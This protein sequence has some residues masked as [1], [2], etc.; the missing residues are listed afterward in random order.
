MNFK[1]ELEL[2]ILSID[3]SIYLF[4]GLIFVSWLLIYFIHHNNYEIVPIEEY[5]KRSLDMHEVEYF[6]ME[7]VEVHNYNLDEGNLCFM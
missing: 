3:E 6:E 4:F 1:D 2:F 5:R 7:Q